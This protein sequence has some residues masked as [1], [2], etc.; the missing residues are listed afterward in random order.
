[1]VTMMVSDQIISDT[2]PR[3]INSLP[4]SKFPCDSV[5]FNA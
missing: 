5:S 2:G 1:M 4:A 3:T